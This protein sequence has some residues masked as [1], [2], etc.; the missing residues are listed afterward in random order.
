M[1][2]QKNL[3]EFVKKAIQTKSN[4]DQEGD[5]AHLI[6][7]EMERLGYDEAFIDSVGN[8]VSLIGDGEKL[9][10]FD[11]HLDTV[12]VNDEQVSAPCIPAGNPV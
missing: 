3:M 1:D 7:E 4:S 10:H 2:H 5:F 9:L 6:V 12:Q 8:A 11:G